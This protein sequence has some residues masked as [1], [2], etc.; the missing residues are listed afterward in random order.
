[1]VVSLRELWW[2][3]LYKKPA[4]GRQS[5]SSSGGVVV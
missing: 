1:M 4:L 5:R 2:R 3:L